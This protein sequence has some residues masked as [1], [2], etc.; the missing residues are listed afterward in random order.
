LRAPVALGF[1]AAG[2]G[3][4]LRPAVCAPALCIRFTAR[5]SPGAFGHHPGAFAGASSRLIVARACPGAVGPGIELVRPHGWRK[6]D[7]VLD[8]LLGPGRD[9]G[10]RGLRLRRVPRADLGG[11]TAHAAAACDARGRGARGPVQRRRPTAARSGRRYTTSVRGRH[12]R[13]DSGG[14]GAPAGGGGGAPAG[15]LP[16]PGRHDRRCRPTRCTTRGQRVEVRTTRKSRRVETRVRTQPPY[17]HIVRPDGW[18]PTWW[19]RRRRCRRGSGRRS[20]ARRDLGGRGHH[21]SGGGRRAPLRR[22]GCGR[23]QPPVAPV[24][25]GRPRTRGPAGAAGPGGSD[26]PSERGS[27]RRR[28]ARGT[29]AAGPAACRR[30]PASS[31]RPSPTRSHGAGAAGTGRHAGAFCGRSSGASSLGHAA[32]GARRPTGARLTG[33]RSGNTLTSRRALRVA[34]FGTMGRR[35]VGYPRRPWRSGTMPST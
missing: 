32:T 29:I 35:F 20:C 2:N 14:R 15:G 33:V 3:L 34:G 25:W 22:M 19:R 7:G 26:R 1:T 12:R 23:W 17:P 21:G 11:S 31:C 13:R 30:T 27:G 5:A 10:R 28:W 18:R 16:T 9:G 8:A 24:L 6:V 4:S